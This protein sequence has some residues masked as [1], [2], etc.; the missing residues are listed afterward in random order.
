MQVAKI[1]TPINLGPL[2]LRHRAVIMARPDSDDSLDDLA[3]IRLAAQGGLLLQP[4]EASISPAETA[5][6]R[7]P[8]LGKNWQTLTNSVRAK[9]GF[10][11]AQL[12]CF[13][14]TTN[15]DLPDACVTACRAM[16]MLALA[17]QFDGAELAL[18][19]VPRG[20]PALLDMVEVLIDV[21]G[22]DRVGVQIAPFAGT[23]ELIDEGVLATFRALLADLSEMEIAY[24]HLSGAIVPG[25][26]DLIAT[27]LM[28]QFRAAY[29]GILIASGGFTP[30][31]AIAAV[32]GRWADLIGFPLHAGDGDDILAALAQSA[33]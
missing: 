16:A 5:P 1:L 7:S 15:V 8:P 19:G 14:N 20:A 9:G 27:P 21:W 17:S 12:S 28:R 23:S 11:V 22:P 13:A 24:V 6:A 3:G 30:K 32:K 4:F 2:Y 18:R 29:P 10:T 33:K 31:T 25:Q 26:E